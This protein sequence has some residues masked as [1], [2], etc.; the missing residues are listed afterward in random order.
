MLI[1]GIE[2]AFIRNVVTP[3]G[4]MLDRGVVFSDL[5]ENLKTFCLT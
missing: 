1:K 2:Y 5:P 3:A 4:L